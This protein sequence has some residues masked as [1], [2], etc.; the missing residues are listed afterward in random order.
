MNAYRSHN[1]YSDTAKRRRTSDV[2]RL[3]VVS[4]PTGAGADYEET[5]YHGRGVCP[6]ESHW[7]PLT[8]YSTLPGLGLLT[9]RGLYN[10]ALFLNLI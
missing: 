5:E 3:A 2:R 4:I 8:I 10:N 9:G 6:C 7:V 1:L